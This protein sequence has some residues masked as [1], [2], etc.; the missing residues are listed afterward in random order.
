MRENDEASY[1]ICNVEKGGGTMRRIAEKGN[2]PATLGGG[3]G[4][5]RDK[6]VRLV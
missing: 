1:G 5:W 2:F 3:R 6:G 4:L